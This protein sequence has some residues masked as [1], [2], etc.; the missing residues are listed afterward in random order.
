MLADAA[1]PALFGLLN[2]FVAIPTIELTINF[3]DLDAGRGGNT[4]LLGVFRNTYA[5]DGMAVEDGQLWQLPD[6][7]AVWHRPG[8]FGGSWKKLTL[9]GCQ[10]GDLE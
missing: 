5:A 10:K 7:F 1:P 3:A 2:H 4:W 9:V 6:S 8:N